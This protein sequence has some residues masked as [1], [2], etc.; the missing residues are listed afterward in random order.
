[1]ANFSLKNHSLTGHNLIEASAGTGKTYTISGI[2]CKLLLQKIPCSKILI[3]TFTNLAKGELIERL[4]SDAYALYLILT[5]KKKIEDSKPFFQ[6][7]ITKQHFNNKEITAH[8]FQELSNIDENILTIHGFCND[9]ASRFFFEFGFAFQENII[10]DEKEIFE[11]TFFQVLQQDIYPLFKVAKESD[12][13]KQNLQKNFLLEYIFN[14]QDGFNGIKEKLIHYQKDL[15]FLT[16]KEEGENFEILIKEY[17]QQ[18]QKIKEKLIKAEYWLLRGEKEYPLDFLIYFSRL[19]E[20]NGNGNKFRNSQ[21]HLKEIQ[22]FFLQEKNSFFICYCFKKKILQDSK[23]NRI[24][25]RYNFPYFLENRK[26]EKKEDEIKIYDDESEKFESEFQKKLNSFLQELNEFFQTSEKIEIAL[27][28]EYKKILEKCYCSLTKKITETKKNLSIKTH[29]DSLKNVL[30]AI[31]NKSDFELKQIRQRYETILIDEFQ[32]TDKKQIEIFDKLFLQ[33][34]IPKNLFF[35]GDPKQSIYSFRGADL[36]SYLSV[37]EKCQVYTLHQNWRSTSGL[38]NSVNF[39]FD[40]SKNPFLNKEIINPKISAG[41]KDFILEKKFGHSVEIW[42]NEL[43]AATDKK[44]EFFSIATANHISSLLSIGVQKEQIGILV[45]NKMQA[46][47]IMEQLNQNQ[48]SYIWNDDE[49]LFQTPEIKDFYLILKAIFLQNKES[50][51]AALSTPLCKN[52]FKLEESFNHLQEVLDYLALL[53]GGQQDISLAKKWVHWKQKINQCFEIWQ[54]ENFSKAMDFFFDEDFV[55]H[56]LIEKNGKQI[57]ANIENCIEICQKEIFNKN[58]NCSG[59]INWFQKKLLISN[60]SKEIHYPVQMVQQTETIQVMTIHKSKG[61]EF[62]FVYCPFTWDENNKDRGEP[63]S[64]KD[65]DVI[66]LNEE[67]KKE[68]VHFSKAQMEAESRRLNYVMLTRAKKKNDFR[69]R[70]HS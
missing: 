16:E 13:Q 28:H 35:I 40:E 48:I 2:F 62:D 12:D 36:N 20:T 45:R 54:E 66:P 37:R 58:L 46:Q 5:D 57:F 23:G 11:K 52:Y 38:V 41:Q 64:V 44:R 39:L 18:K 55:A 51:I 19:I 30:E 65:A 17:Q 15:K 59:V 69:S 6:E 53:N 70:K 7:I 29:D 25:N 14:F 26:K 1:M 50:S 3:V 9:L 68:S 49:D 47:F 32:D 63:Y 4:H 43:D 60:N 31:Q 8:I 67:V 56:L 34:P 21:K 22:N 33:S 10:E 61:L 24:Y 27:Q 42:L